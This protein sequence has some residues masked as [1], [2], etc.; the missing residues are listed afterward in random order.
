MKIIEIKEFENEMYE[1]DNKYTPFLIKRIDNEIINF[2]IKCIVD[3]RREMN[4]D[5]II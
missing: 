1:C 4:D 5:C 2:Q 3:V